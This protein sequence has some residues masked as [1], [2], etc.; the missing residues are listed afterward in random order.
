MG[1][2]LPRIKKRE[3][4]RC[5]RLSFRLRHGVSEF[6]VSVKGVKCLTA[7]FAFMLLPVED[8][9]FELFTGCLSRSTAYWA[10]HY[11]YPRQTSQEFI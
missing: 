10:L 9:E 8:P 5:P 7:S 1:Q 2:R 11:I 3:W 4:G 6:T